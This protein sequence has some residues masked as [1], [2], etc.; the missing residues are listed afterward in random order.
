MRKSGLDGPACTFEQLAQL[1]SLTMD[2]PEARFIAENGCGATGKGARSFA[3]ARSARGLGLVVACLSFDARYLANTSAKL[4]LELAVANPSGGGV[5]E[6]TRAFPSAALN[7]ALDDGLADVNGKA[8]ATTRFEPAPL[9]SVPGRVP[10][11]VALDLTRVRG[12]IRRN[13]L[14]TVGVLLLAALLAVVMGSRL[15][16]AMSQALARLNAAFKRVEQHRYEHVDGV[17]TGDEIEALAAAST[18]WWT[19][20]VNATSCEPPWAST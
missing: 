14:L 2:V 18:R 11:V 1:G 3:I 4:G 19:A 12:V 9:A 16:G 7:E 20:C 6:R 13:L 8:W 5:G 15:A 17:K 10:I